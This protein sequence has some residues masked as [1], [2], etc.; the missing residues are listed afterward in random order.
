M[1]FLHFV[2]YSSSLVGNLKDEI[3][4]AALELWSL[5]IE[6]FSPGILKFGTKII[7]LL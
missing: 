6:Q 1:L 5:N 3:P 4:G 2:L 7:L